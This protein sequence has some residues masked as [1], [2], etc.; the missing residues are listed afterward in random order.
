VFEGEHPRA[1]SGR[2][3]TRRFPG[4]A[5]GEIALFVPIEWDDDVIGGVREMAPTVSTGAPPQFQ[6]VMDVPASRTFD[7]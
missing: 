4:G 6:T 5:S 2:K 7:H 3:H 1:S